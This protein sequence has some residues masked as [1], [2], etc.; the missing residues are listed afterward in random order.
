MENIEDSKQ[1]N[2]INIELAED[3]ESCLNESSLDKSS[4]ERINL[5]KQTF[6]SK[7]GITR[8]LRS[9]K[10]HI[11]VILLVILDCLCISLELILDLIISINN[12]SRENFA[13]YEQ[14]FNSTI[15]KKSNYF[16]LVHSLD[17]KSISILISV[18]HVLKFL[19]LSILCF[20]VIEIILKLIFTPRE[21]FK[22]IWGILDAIVVFVSFFLDILLLRN[23]QLL[24]TVT[25][26]LTLFRL[27][28]I[29]RILSGILMTMEKKSAKK[30]D[31]LLKRIEKLKK[32][33]AELRE[34]LEQKKALIDSYN[35]KN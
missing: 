27:W 5:E 13:R 22:S 26:L 9:N 35:T 1:Y 16:D 33:N 17:A 15:R 34:E 28:R 30:I 2:L 20:F 23:K 25:G 8:I 12:D 29:A 10:L 11:I 24:H 7:G 32:E 4:P 19:S 21:V 3:A 14:A 18:E 6:F 31:K